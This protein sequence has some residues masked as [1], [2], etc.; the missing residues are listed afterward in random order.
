MKIKSEKLRKK[1]KSRGT[2]KRI[3]FL[4]S[5]AFAWRAFIRLRLKIDGKRRSERKYF[6][7]ASFAR[8]IWRKFYFFSLPKYKYWI[9]EFS[10]FVVFRPFV[11]GEKF[12]SQFYNALIFCHAALA[13]LP[14][15]NNKS[16]RKKRDSAT[17]LSHKLTSFFFST[18]IKLFGSFLQQKGANFQHINI[19]MINSKIF[20]ILTRS[21][22]PKGCYNFLETLFSGQI[23]IK[24]CRKF[25]FC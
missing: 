7:Y 10:C 20:S 18:S 4:V 21:I 14:A 8:I 2:S 24:F 17:S 25:K 5:F 6:R 19:R 11:T 3:F 1:K 12:T 23:V 22:T 16:S 13:S 9:N 15:N